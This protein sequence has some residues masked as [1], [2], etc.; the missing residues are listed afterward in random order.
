M[1]AR[2][3]IVEDNQTNLELMAYLLR[4]FGHDVMTAVDGVHALET[5]ASEPIDLVLMD[6]Q[7]PEMDGYETVHRLKRNPIWES[8]PVIAVTAFAMVGDRDRIL[9]SEFNGYLAKPIDPETFVRQ[10]DAYLP[11]PLQSEG[12]AQDLAASPQ[13]HTQSPTPRRSGTILAVDDSDTNLELVTA[14]LQPLGY[15]VVTTRDVAQALR[16]MHDR[17]P[18]LIVSDLEMSGRSGLDLLDLVKNSDN[19]AIRSI[20]FVLISSGDMDRDRVRAQ[21]GGV[22]R[23]IARPISIT[24]L[25]AEIDACLADRQVEGGAR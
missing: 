19:E 8:V 7:M 11:T 20:P 18:D 5:L 9:K 17:M 1:P 22:T 2:I 13:T 25:I 6:L 10:V 4:S 3:L 16:V 12:N 24:S 21:V 23:F 15:T 14:S